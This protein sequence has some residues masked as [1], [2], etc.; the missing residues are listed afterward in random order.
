VNPVEPHADIRSLAT[1][2]FQL[3]TACLQ[4]GFDAN[5]AML[6]LLRMVANSGGA[7]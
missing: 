1:N 6:L 5:Q 7:Q 4:A 2:W 3:Y